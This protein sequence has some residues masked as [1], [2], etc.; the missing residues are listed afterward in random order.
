MNRILHIHSRQ[1]HALSDVYDLI[2]KNLEGRCSYFGRNLDALYD[3]FSDDYFDWVVIHE[4]HLLKQALTH[5]GEN[6]SEYYQFLDV[7]TDADGIDIVFQD[8]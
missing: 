4:K 1:I 5:E 8:D 3:I 7:L 2:E 6:M